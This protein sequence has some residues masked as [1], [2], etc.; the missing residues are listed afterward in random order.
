MILV[1]ECLSTWI[2]IDISRYLLVDYI[3]NGITIYYYYAGTLIYI[4]GFYNLYKLIEL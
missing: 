1:P 3:L 4:Y 2:L